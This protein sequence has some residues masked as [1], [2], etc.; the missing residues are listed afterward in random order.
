M[1]FIRGRCGVPGFRLGRILSDAGSQEGA[2]GGEPVVV[3]LVLGPHGTDG[4]LR[5]KSLSDVPQRFD[6]GRELFLRGRPY[7]VAR[8]VLRPPEQ[9][10]LKLEGVRTRAAARALAGEEVTVAAAS[11]PVLPEG[12]YYHFQLLGLRV[13]TEEGAELGHIRE[14]IVTGS[15]DVYVVAGP[16][17]EVLLP[18]VGSVVLGVDLELGVMRVRLMGGMG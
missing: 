15:N 16:A 9:V 5:V 10:I 7:R 8:S 11:A 2:A 4:S 1:G 13:V 6:A 14:V 12:E 18:A 17:G 3:G